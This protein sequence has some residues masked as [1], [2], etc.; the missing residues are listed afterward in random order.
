MGYND[1]A[2]ASD[3]A[4]TPS[5][6]MDTDDIAKHTPSPNRLHSMDSSRTD[7]L[8]VLPA[9]PDT[10]R[11]GLDTN[12]EEFPLLDDPWLRDTLNHYRQRGKSAQEG[13]KRDEA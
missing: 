11:V 3:S 12:S 10:P 2:L 4:N 7:N 6:G 1:I 13:E 8:P 9:L 5:T